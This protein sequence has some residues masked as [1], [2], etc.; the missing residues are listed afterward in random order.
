[1]IG[2]NVEKIKALF[3][4]SDFDEGPHYLLSQELEFEYAKSIVTYSISFIG[5]VV[6]LK[7]ALGID[8][9]IEEGLSIAMGA[10]LLSA[11]ISFE[12][13]QGIIRELR[14]KIT[15]SAIRILYRKT[16]APMCLGAAIGYA[17]KYFGVLAG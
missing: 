14:L 15:P 8:T 7:S 3:E 6:T 13:Q 11:L 4:N 10:A 9:P 2:F 17:L 16:A 1:M 12:N 5:G